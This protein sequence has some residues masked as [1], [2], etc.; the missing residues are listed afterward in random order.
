MAES[1]EGE[2]EGGNLGVV[3]GQVPVKASQ[4]KELTQVF[5][6]ARRWPI[7]NGLLDGKA[8]RPEGVTRCPRHSE[9]V[10]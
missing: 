1:Q 10:Q 2:L 3:T 6:L 8:K 9:A 4:T 5:N 7:T